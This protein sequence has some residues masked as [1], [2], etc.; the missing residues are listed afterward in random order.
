MPPSDRSDLGSGVRVWR[1][2]DGEVIVTSPRL[3]FDWRTAAGGT[4]GTAVIL[5]AETFEVAEHV[6]LAAGDRWI[7]QPWGAAETMRVVV[8]LDAGYVREVEEGAHAEARERWFRT[9]GSLVLPLLGLAPA[10]LQRRWADR[11]HFDAGRATRWSAVLEIAWGGLGSIQLLVIMLG[12]EAFMPLAVAYVAPLVLV[13]GLVRLALVAADDEPIG[14]PLG[15]PLLV[16]AGSSTS[17]P[18]PVTPM[19]RPVDTER[20]R[21][22]VSSP[23]LRRDWQN[24]GI[25]RYHGEAYELETTDH[26]GSQWVYG[27]RHTADDD[28]NAPLL[29]LVPPPE[30]VYLPRHARSQPPPLLSTVLISAAV[31][32]GPRS[33]QERWA[34]HLRLSPL[35]LT[36]I[37]AGSELIGGLVNLGG[38]HDAGP[39]VLLDAYLVG[40]GLVRLGSALAGRPLGSIWGWILRPLY[41]RRLRAVGPDGLRS[42]GAGPPVG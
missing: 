23:V 35:W 6:P 12:G 42:E 1:G 36:G 2:D 13:S 7:L 10:R 8:R 29:R 41:R 3:R 37:G 18:D 16:A 33:D 38:R 32:L 22:E 24:G 17:P 25:L 30:T 26:Q 4:P 39:L 15:L 20:G 19:V 9:G 14:S 11:W 34:E 21:L 31:T 27:F 5:A 28:T 40:E